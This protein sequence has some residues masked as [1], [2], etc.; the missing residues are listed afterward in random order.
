MGE[1]YRISCR[2]GYERELNIGGGLASGNLNMVNR[3]F[4]KERLMA[5][6]ANY[7]NN[8]IKNFVIDN[9]LSFCDK[10]KEIMATAVLDVLLTDNQKIEII[11]DCSVC[12]NRIQILNDLPK[13]PKCGQ[14][15]SKQEIGNWD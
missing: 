2:C 4:S 7:K 5:F 10:C 13:C 1:I 6:T 14:K 3:I 8:R 12:G 11:N 15:M 9:K